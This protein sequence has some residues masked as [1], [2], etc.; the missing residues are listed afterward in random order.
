MKKKQ[1]M[2]DFEQILRQSDN[3]RMNQTDNVVMGYI[4]DN[5]EALLFKDGSSLEYA[6]E[7]QTGTIVN[8]PKKE[9][10]INFNKV[11]D[12]DSN[13]E[14]Y[15]LTILD[16]KNS[17]IIKDELLNSELRS[18]SIDNTG[19]GFLKKPDEQLLS[20]SVDLNM[21]EVNKHLDE[22][23]LNP[24]VIQS[25]INK[26]NNEYSKRTVLDFIKEKLDDDASSLNQKRIFKNRF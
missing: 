16:Q 11:S 15:V 25:V 22:I 4:T 5:G 12:D 18:V 3:Y 20:K 8:N 10:R 26:K 21:S 6:D 1:S 2:A 24:K 23:G 19:S 17:N 9:V 13:K 14:S 7:Y